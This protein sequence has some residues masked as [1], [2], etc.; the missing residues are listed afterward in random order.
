MLF[1]NLLSG[2]ILSSWEVVATVIETERRN[3]NI[4]VR[5]FQQLAAHQDIST[6]R[7]EVQFKAGSRN[8][9]IVPST[10]SVFGSA[11]ADN[12]GTISLQELTEQIGEKAAQELWRRVD[13]DGDGEVTLEELQH[14]M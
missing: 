8:V 14:A 11:D 12:S 5:Q 7:L 10:K 6:D 9:R 3:A 13:L 1:V 4:S 2:V